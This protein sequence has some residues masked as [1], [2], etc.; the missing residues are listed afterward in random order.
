MKVAKNEKEYKKMSEIALNQIKEKQ[1]E[2][3]LKARGIKEIMLIG[4]TFFGKEVNFISEK[5]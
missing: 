3:E 2:I 5:I 1:Y 4:I